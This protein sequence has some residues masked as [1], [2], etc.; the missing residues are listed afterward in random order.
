[1]FVIHLRRQRAWWQCKRWR[2]G[3]IFFL[4]KLYYSV[5]YKNNYC[6]FR[7][8]LLRILKFC[9]DRLSIDNAVFYREMSPGTSPGTHTFWLLRGDN[10]G[11]MARLP[12]RPKWRDDRTPQPRDCKSMT[13]IACNSCNG[14]LLRFCSFH[15][16][17][18][19]C[20][21]K[22]TKQG[23][24]VGGVSNCENKKRPEKA[25]RAAMTDSITA[26]PCTSY[27]SST[28]RGL[29]RE[30]H[31]SIHNTTPPETTMIQEINEFD[32]I[33][34]KNI[35]FCPFPRE[36]SRLVVVSSWCCL[37]L[38][39]GKHVSTSRPQRPHMYDYMGRALPLSPFSSL[40]GTK[41]TTSNTV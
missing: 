26:C 24:S 32:W 13:T 15:R 41:Y 30:H 11:H 5:L 31:P 16:G 19:R 38:C 23:V 12:L 17:M 28:M 4:Q 10:F 9:I 40:S 33:L 22:M 14:R 29:L 1:V 39:S 27:V 2:K 3:Y 18:S 7:Y 36:S 20:D 8:L 34:T 35:A 21:W 6:I 37:L 25:S